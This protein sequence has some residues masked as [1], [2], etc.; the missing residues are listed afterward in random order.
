MKIDWDELY[1]VFSRILIVFHHKLWNFHHLHH[2]HKGEGFYLLGPGKKIPG[3][4]VRKEV[5][6]FQIC[7]RV[8]GY[9]GESKVKREDK[10]MR[11]R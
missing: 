8:F 4:N 5:L 7:V 3:V 11:D 2:T 9:R 6:D 10:V 1:L